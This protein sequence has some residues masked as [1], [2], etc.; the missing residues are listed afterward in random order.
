MMVNAHLS[1]IQESGYVHAIFKTQEGNRVSGPVSIDLATVDFEVKRQMYFINRNIM[2]R[3]LIGFLNQRKAA[4]KNTDLAEQAQQL[5]ATIYENRMRG[6][7]RF[8]GVV[9]CNYPGFMRIV[10]CEDSRYHKHYKKVIEPILYFCI[11]KEN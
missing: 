2:A 11:G 10:P 1:Q 5:Y 7:H 8:V 3:L 6:F 4:L 9:E